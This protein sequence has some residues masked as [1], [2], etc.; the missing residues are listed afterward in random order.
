[1]HLIKQPEPWLYI[2]LLASLL[3]GTLIIIK[4]YNAIG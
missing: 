4:H 1:M 3:V 2:V